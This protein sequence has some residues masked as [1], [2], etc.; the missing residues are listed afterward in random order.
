[1]TRSP[2]ESSPNLG[3]EGIAGT[4]IPL[5]DSFGRVA[6]DLRVSLTD[7][8]NL[9]CQ[10]CM[11]EQGLDWMPKP[12]LLTDDELVRIVRVGVERLGLTEIRITGGEPLLRPGLPAIIKSVSQLK[13]RPALS[14]T[15]NGIGLARIVNE[16]VE[17]GLERVNVSLDTLD[18]QVFENM[19]KRDRLSDVLA[20]LDAAQEAGLHPI[21]VNAV[22]LRSVNEDEAVP[23]MEYCLERG[24]QLRFIEQMP[25]DP[26]HGWS[27]DKM[28]T[29]QE[30]F[31][32]ISLKWT[33]T[34]DP[35]QRGSAPA[36]TWLIDGGPAKVG[37]IASITDPF[38]GA[39][40]RNRLTA[41]GK[42]RTCLFTNREFD[43]RSLVRAER[44]DDDIAAAWVQAAATKAFGHGVNA[45]DFNQ[46]E[47]PMS[48]IGG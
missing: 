43:L 29:K 2:G 34:E 46:P 14:L 35:A 1:M 4:P 41:D 48:A 20:G 3:D 7:R 11:P 19:A 38:C 23:L 36:E 16:L 47:R 10:Y 13:P 27:R 6:T 24:F 31:D 9:R 28:I 26:M 18:P 42:I 8:C 45:P 32:A 22:L 30:I 5:V 21:K 17:A 44:S 39:C 40:N 33:L 15:T 25:L 12:E 37:I